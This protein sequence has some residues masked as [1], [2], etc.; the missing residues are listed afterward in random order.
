MR[1]TSFTDDNLRTPMR[2]A[3]APGRAL[4]ATGLTGIAL[5]A[6]RSMAARGGMR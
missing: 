6:P 3:G 2:M 5:A 1:L 4:P